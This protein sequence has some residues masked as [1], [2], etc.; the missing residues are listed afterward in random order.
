MLK[1]V[2]GWAAR[3]LAS[4]T[5]KVAIGPVVAGIVLA[6]VIAVSMAGLARSRDSL[7]VLHDTNGA[8]V[9]HGQA[10]ST[11]LLRLQASIFQLVMLLSMQ[12]DAEEIGKLREAVTTSVAA[13]RKLSEADADMLPDGML[14]GYEEKLAA[15]MQLMQFSPTM[16]FGSVVELLHQLSTVRNHVAGKLSERN[17]AADGLYSAKLRDANQL[18]IRFVAAAAL[19][20]TVL[21]LVVILA[22]RALIKPL[23]ALTATMAALAIGNPPRWR[24]PF[25]SGCAATRS[26]TWRARSRCF[27]TTSSRRTGWRRRTRRRA[28]P[29]SGAPR[30]SMS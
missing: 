24:A 5:F 4:I 30:C 7:V 20:A 8:A 28:W 12:G 13:M 18:R 1:R 19:L 6:G 25:P 2:R 3:C 15:T 16:A 17:A 11:E 22:S 9:V 10:A 23:A 21:I 14:S 29:R 26:A 27:A